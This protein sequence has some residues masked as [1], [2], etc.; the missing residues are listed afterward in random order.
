[1][2]AE[3]KR[4]QQLMEDMAT[5][6]KQVPGYLNSIV[7]FIILLLCK[8]QDSVYFECRSVSLL[9]DQITDRDLFLQVTAR[10]VS[11]FGYDHVGPHTCFETAGV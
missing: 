5:M 1:M 8:T 7:D 9:H 11:S 3:E 2:V 10:N 4:L 6:M